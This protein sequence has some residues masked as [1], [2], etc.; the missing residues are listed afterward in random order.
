MNTDQAE[1]AHAID[2]AISG[3]YTF[4]QLVRLYPEAHPDIMRSLAAMTKHPRANEDP[5]RLALFQASEQFV[6]AQKNG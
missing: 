3:L 5:D 4:V 6:L 2:R 1:L